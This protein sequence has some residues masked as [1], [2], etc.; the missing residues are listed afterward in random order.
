MLYTRFLLFLWRCYGEE[1]E[2]GSELGFFV[3]V[4][5]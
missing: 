4:R 2:G 1:N 5:M 3:L